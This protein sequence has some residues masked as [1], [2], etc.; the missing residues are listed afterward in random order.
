MLLARP[1]S[2]LLVGAVK[3]KVR[4]SSRFTRCMASSLQQQQQQHRPVPSQ[5]KFFKH[6]RRR[7]LHTRPL[8]STVGQDGDVSEEGQG[9]E[10]P[11][12]LGSL[13]GDMEAEL[14]GKTTTKKLRLR[15]IR[16]ELEF[17]RSRA[18][19]LPETLTHEQWK[20]LLDFSERDH[21]TLYLDAILQGTEE[22]VFPELERLDEMAKDGLTFSEE[23]FAGMYD[24]KDFETDGEQSLQ[25]RIGMINYVYD[26]M[27]QAGEMVPVTIKK[28]HLKELISLRSIK[29]AEK[30][31]AYLGQGR[32]KEVLDLVKKRARQG[33]AAVTRAKVVKER[34]EEEHLVYALGHNTIRI[35]LLDSTIEKQ[36]AWNVIREFHSWGQPMV[37]DLSFMQTMSFKQAKSVAFRELPYAIRNNKRSR[38]P[39]ALHFT[40]YDE[41]CPKTRAFLQMMPN[42][43]E[44]DQPFHCTPKCHT[45]LFDRN[46]LVYLTPD[47]RTDLLEFNED[48]VYILGALNDGGAGRP[49][50]LAQAK[51]D[52]IRHAR[53]PM[54]RF[55]G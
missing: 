42:L 30:F 31:F 2:R 26:Q 44:D 40:N 14:V 27:R 23:T 33:R 53:L 52:G 16:I 20:R 50:T 17:L 36:E 10:P 12:P 5:L 32:S 11:D 7:D 9:E 41:S 1:T 21:R 35:R 49:T 22:D 48:D 15:N 54:K 29:A 3:D 37:I 24:P 47:S 18:F 51:R 25:D 13:T 4:P 39:F 8:S 45:E 6:P 19:P 38:A 34:A 55:V 28:K 46:R 43:M